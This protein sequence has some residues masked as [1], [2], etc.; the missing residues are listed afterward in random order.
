MSSARRQDFGSNV[1]TRGQ[2][3]R[4]REGV[5]A[6]PGAGRLGRGGGGRTRA[7]EGAGH[8]QPRK[9]QFQNPT[10]KTKQL[11]DPVEVGIV[12]E[13]DDQLA[14]RVELPTVVDLGEA[15]L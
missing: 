8:R 6:E 2:E 1:S 7:G 5:G 15:L 11:S 3:A 14:E 9:K 12:K 10:K 4:A 13:C